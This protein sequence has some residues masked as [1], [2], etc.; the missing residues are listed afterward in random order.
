MVR[1]KTWSDVDVSAYL[2]GELDAATRETFEAAMVRDQALRRQVDDLR[3]VISLMRV[4][5]LRE[6][7]RNYLLTPGM[8]AETSSQPAKRRRTPLLLMRLAT[9]AAAAAFVVTVGL[10]VVSRGGSPAMVTQQDFE[11]SIDAA[12]VGEAEKAVEEPMMVEMAAPMEENAE[13]AMEPKQETAIAPLSDQP[14]PSGAMGQGIGGG[15]QDESTEQRVIETKPVGE[16]M[17]EDA[18][19][20][21]PEDGGSE[22]GVQPEALSLAAVEPTVVTP[23]VTLEPEPVLYDAV[24]RGSDAT[25]QRAVFP[26]PW[27]PGV[28]GV[29]TLILVG[30]T[31]WMSRKQ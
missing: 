20:E 19:K 9:S 1:Q 6:P 23:T 15:G 16:E 3:E 17:V 12:T 8:V 10:G 18:A 27:L 11:Y 4:A 28:L 7:P 5:P 25:V 24:E 2:D 21:A 26:P 29:V 14:Q 30:V 13:K 31:I 22:G